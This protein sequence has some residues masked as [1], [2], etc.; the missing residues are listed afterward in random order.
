MMLLAGVCGVGGS[1][2][3]L[4]VNRETRRCSIEPSETSIERWPTAFNNGQ[5][6]GNR[7]T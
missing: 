4:G 7:I 3:L 6:H 5:I 1:V 2:T